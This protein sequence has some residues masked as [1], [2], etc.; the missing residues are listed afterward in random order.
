MAAAW[1]DGAGAGDRFGD[2]PCYRARV[3]TCVFCERPIAAN[4]PSVGRRPIAAHAACA[5]AALADDR[6]WDE[7]ATGTPEAEAPSEAAV[8]AGRTGGCL[9]ASVLALLA[10]ARLAR[11]ARR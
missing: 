3:I 11:A 4:T 2:P 10:F 9:A 1:S 5:D 7:I 8:P 6:H